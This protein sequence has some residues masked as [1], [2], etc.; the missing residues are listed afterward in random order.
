VEIGAHR[1]VQIELAAQRRDAVGVVEAHPGHAG[2]ERLAAGL[3]E[4]A[5][6]L[7]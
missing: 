5:C 7:T 4:D 1:G 3:R 6:E 2:L